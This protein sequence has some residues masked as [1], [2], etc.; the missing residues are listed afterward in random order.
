[1]NNFEEKELLKQDI[2]ESGNIKEYISVMQK[3]PTVEVAEILWEL[4]EEELEEV[5]VLFTAEQQG[6]IISD[7]D[8]ETKYWLFQ[9]MDRRLFAEM[10]EHMHSSDR[11][12]FYRELEKQEQLLLLPYLTKAIR[13]DV[14]KLSTYEPDTAG[15]IMSTDFATVLESMTCAQAIDKVRKDAP[16]KKMIYYIYVVDHHMKMQ[17]F[18]TLKNLII[19]PPNQLVRDTLHTDYIYARIEEDKE[20]VANKIQKYDLVAI[21]ILNEHDQLA[22][23]VTHDDAIE[24]IR[25]EA[26]EDMEKFMGLTPGDEESDYLEDSV[27][28]HYKRRIIWLISLAALSIFSGFIVHAYEDALAALIIL[29]L[30][31]PMMAATGGNTGS[32]AATVVITAL[33]LG[34]ITLKDWIKVIYKEL[35]I[36]LMLGVSLGCLTILKV[37]VLSSNAD[38]PAMYS[39][40]N[41]AMVI[42][43]AMTIQVITATLIGSGLPI[44]VKNIGGD[45]TVA[46]SPAITTIV[47]ITG[48]LIYFGMATLFFDLQ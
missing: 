25:A 20:S 9:H 26:T 42:S 38:L 14:I 32:Q 29:V 10:F 30:Y 39:L 7:F 44:L 27:W 41:I 28:T 40:I 5:L 2:I 48:L 43:L 36:G 11:A 8:Y 35:R 22:G 18:V 46:A 45:P 23:I 34:Q 17:G 24:I 3:M 1:M 33:S 13:E 21:P 15:G 4:K 6:Q 31:M 19:S 47:D 16:S 37:F 12:D